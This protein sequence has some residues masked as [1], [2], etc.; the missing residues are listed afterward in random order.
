MIIS[1]LPWRLIRNVGYSFRRI[2][3]TKDVPKRGH[4]LAECEPDKLVEMLR[5]DHMRSGWI[6]SYHYKGEDYNLSRAEY[7][8]EGHGKM[9]LHIRIF[10]AKRDRCKIM[11]HFED[12]PIEK[13]RLHLKGE[14]QDIEKGLKIT[15]KILAKNEIG[16]ARV[17]ARQK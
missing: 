11:A 8:D 15:E 16:H 3:G 12:C 7:S 2:F 14:N 6:L 1:K 5:K 17:E 10:D 9:Q 4:I 13:P